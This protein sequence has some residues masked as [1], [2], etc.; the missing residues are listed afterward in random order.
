[1]LPGIVA[2]KTTGLKCL[3]L[4]VMNLPFI[5]LPAPFPRQVVEKAYAAPV[6][7][8]PSPRLRGEGAPSEAEAG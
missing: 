2:G 7:V 5:R 6:A 4:L 3:D 1:M 8:P